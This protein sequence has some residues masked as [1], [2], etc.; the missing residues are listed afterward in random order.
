MIVN[1]NQICYFK[2]EHDLPNPNQVV[3]VPRADLTSSTALSQQKTKIRDIKKCNDNAWFCILYL[4]REQR[5]V[6]WT[7]T[8]SRLT[9]EKCI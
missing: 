6:V 2:P 9:G 4:S 1:Q 8:V 7:V 3:S 5:H